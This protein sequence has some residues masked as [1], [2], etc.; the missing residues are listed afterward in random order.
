MCSSTRWWLLLSM[1]FE[2][3]AFCLPR[4][5]WPGDLWA[6]WLNQIIRVQSHLLKKT[7]EDPKL[8]AGMRE[9]LGKSGS[10]TWAANKGELL[11]LHPGI[12]FLIGLERCLGKDLPWWPRSREPRCQW[13]D[14]REQR[15]RQGNQNHSSQGL[16]AVEINIPHMWAAAG[17]GFLYTVFSVLSLPLFTVLGT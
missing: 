10:S 14:S 17:Q 4:K 16:F 12:W 15:K 8:R 3:D 7:R 1:S 11:G 2:C 9:L 13:G 6:S 5:K